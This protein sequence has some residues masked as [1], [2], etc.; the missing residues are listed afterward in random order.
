MINSEQKKALRRA[1]YQDVDIMY[2]FFAGNKD[3]EDDGFEEALETV[4][5]ITRDE[6][7][8]YCFEDR[9]FFAGILK[10]AVKSSTDEDFLN[11]ILNPDLNKAYKTASE[12]SGSVVSLEDFKELMEYGGKEF[13]KTFESNNMIE[14]DDEMDEDELADVVGGISDDELMKILKFILKTIKHGC[15]VGASLVDTP[16][17]A[18][19]ISEIKAGDIIFS[20]DENNNR[21][22]SKV[23]DTISAEEKIIEVIFENGKKWETTSSQWFYDGN[24]FYDIWQHNEHDIFSLEGSSKVKS[25]TET[26]RKDKVYDIVVDGM[27]IMFINGMAAE[28]YGL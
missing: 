11:A 28:G 3:W 18:K 5:G 19:P 10:I 20:L 8:Q 9:E 27:N 2:D 21:V 23:T 24:K 7:D 17:G 25:I 13:F 1:M 14:A 6:Y 26:G 16:T 22:E 4:P 12:V 15:F